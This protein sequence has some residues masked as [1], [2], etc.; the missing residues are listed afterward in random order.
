MKV[1]ID[2]G[3]TRLKRAV[4]DGHSVHDFRAV[5]HGGGSSA[6]DFDALWKGIENIESAWIASVAPPELDTAV[7][8][9]LRERFGRAVH[10]VRSQVHACGVTSAY[11]HPEDL[12]VDRF[13]SLIAVHALEKRPSVVV[14]C[15]TALTLDALMA[16]GTHMGG[17]IVPGLRLMQESLRTGTARLGEVQSAGAVEMADNT[18]DAIESGIQ[19]ATVAVI[20]RFVGT[21]TGRLGVAPL[22]ILSGGDALRVGAALTISHRIEAE[23][24]LRGLAQFADIRMS[25]V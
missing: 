19:L 24:V 14:S 23:I 7:A 13:L 6:I 3:N 15:G 18:G 22:V 9:S 1:L 21:A 4:W 8:D 17:L 25:A 16:N 20:E 11:A 10:F 2:I 5:A 12:G